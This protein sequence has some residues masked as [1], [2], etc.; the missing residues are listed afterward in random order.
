MT[1]SET[2]YP[3]VKIDQDRREVFVKGK[4]IYIPPAEFT[5]LAA[6]AGAPD[7]I[8]SRVYLREVLREG[9]SELIDLRTIDQHVSRLRRRIARDI[10][11]TVFRE[12]YRLGR[13]DGQAADYCGW[14]NS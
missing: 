8:V 11:E 10:I 12:G 6:V 5:I 4:R 13:G 2:L 14:R 1:I 3:G 9:S 7:R